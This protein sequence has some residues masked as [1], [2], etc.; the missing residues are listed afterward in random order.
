[1]GYE[2]GTGV[3]T[4]LQKKY[5]SRI[6]IAG[7]LVADTRLLLSDWDPDQ[8]MQMN[9]ERIARENTLAK[10]SRARLKKELSAFKGRYLLDPSVTAALRTMVRAHAP[11][12]L[13]H[14]ILYYL[15]IQADPLVGDFVAHKIAPVYRTG[16]RIITTRQTKDWLLEAVAAGQTEG[17]WSESTAERIAQGILATLRDFDIIYGK[18]KKLLHQPI[19]TSPAFAGIAFLIHRREPSAAK[20]L[21]HP[22][23]ERFLMERADVERRFLQA[24]Q[25]R[26]LTY[27]AAG[28]VIRLDFP[29]TTIEEYA[30]VL[31]DRA[32]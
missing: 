8:P 21:A 23:W 15:T 18:A 2:G 14:P 25:E 10:G 13:L 27:Q 26:L 28:R 31:V 3:A 32:L 11:A 9:L 16:A 20:V 24:H 19:I 1:M 12:T 6:I 4:V 30:R 22:I 17:A 29:A 7:A 5:S